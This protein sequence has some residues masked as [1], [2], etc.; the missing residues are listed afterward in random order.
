MRPP[1]VR[2]SRA[3]VRCRD[4]GRGLADTAGC[5]LLIERDIPVRVS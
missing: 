2:P 3:W 1:S 5:P 4:L